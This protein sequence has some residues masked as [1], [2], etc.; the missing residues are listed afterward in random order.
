MKKRL[1]KIFHLRPTWHIKHRKDPKRFLI[2][3]YKCTKATVLVASEL[4]TV[5]RSQGCAINT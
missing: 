5:F 2:S 4:K 1:T 3:N